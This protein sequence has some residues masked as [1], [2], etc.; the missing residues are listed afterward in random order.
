MG[1]NLEESKASKGLAI[2]KKIWK[3]FIRTLPTHAN[4]ITNIKT[5]IM[6]GEI[7]NLMFFEKFYNIL[8]QLFVTIRS[9]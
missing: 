5:Y 8:L 6:V 3:L 2:D 9:R 4:M 1:K 7:F